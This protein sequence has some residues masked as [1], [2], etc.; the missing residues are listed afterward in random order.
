MDRILSSG[1]SCDASRVLLKGALMLK[2]DEKTLQ[3]VRQE[4]FEVAKQK[5]LTHLDNILMTH[6]RRPCGAYLT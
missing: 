3:S 6:L 2:F 5:G 1:I 4:L